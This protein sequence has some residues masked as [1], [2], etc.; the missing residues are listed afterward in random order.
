MSAHKGNRMQL[1]KEKQK[2]AL[3][4]AENLAGEFD[5]KEAKEFA[6]KHQ[7][8]V[9]YSNFKLLYDMVTDKNFKISQKTYLMIAGALAYVV[10]PIDIIPDFIPWVG[11][12]DDIFVVGFV[13]KSIDD[14]I[15]RYKAFKGMYR[16][17]KADV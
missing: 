14:D 9:W 10:L 4:K 17:E 7:G 11:F 16:E 3:I 12:I 13:M 15:Q 2:K 8:A 6:R 5:P 1:D